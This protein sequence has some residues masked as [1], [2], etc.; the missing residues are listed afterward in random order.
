[1]P[2]YEYHCIECDK[3]FEFIQSI[4]DDPI[5]KLKDCENKNCYLKKL[6]SQ[7]AFHLKGGGWFKDG[8]SKEK[9]EKNES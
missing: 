3:Y 6:I 9:K 8:Y 5:E 4:N 1:M 7:C 2:I